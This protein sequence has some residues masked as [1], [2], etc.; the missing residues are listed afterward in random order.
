MLVEHASTEE[1]SLY[2]TLFHRQKN[3]SQEKKQKGKEKIR[4]NIRYNAALIGCFMSR[5]RKLY[6]P[7]A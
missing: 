6:K 2:I 1:C 7:Q 5:D 3:G 4:Y